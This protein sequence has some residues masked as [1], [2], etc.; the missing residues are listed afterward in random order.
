MIDRCPDV[1]LAT[2]AG[3]ADCVSPTPTTTR[4]AAEGAAAEG[5]ETRRVVDAARRL[6]L[7]RGDVAATMADSAVEAGVAMQS[8]HTAGRSRADLRHL[9]TD[10]ALAGD[11]QE[12]VLVDRPVY[13]AFTAEPRPARHIGNVAGSVAATMER[14]VPVWIDHREAAAVVRGPPPNSLRPIVD[15]TRPSEP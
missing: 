7:E 10:L 6:S 2:N 13:D 5:A 8:V 15:A 3:R 11:S 12:I 4:A 9:V 14:P 1:P